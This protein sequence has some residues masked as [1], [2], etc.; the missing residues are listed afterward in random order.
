[1]VSP[2]NIGL[3]IDHD[4]VDDVAD[5]ESG[6]GS[7]PERL[8]ERIFIEKVDYLFVN[9]YGVIFAAFVLSSLLA[10]SLWLISKDIVVVYWIVAYS[11]ISVVRIQ[12]VRRY[13]SNPPTDVK[14]SRKWAFIWVSSQLLPGIM[15]GLAS[16]LF[17]DLNNLA[18]VAIIVIFTLGITTGAVSSTASYYP[19]Y[20]SFLIPSTLPL[21]YLRR[22]R[23]IRLRRQ[24]QEM[25]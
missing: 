24:A 9:A 8:E 5:R 4:A 21:A 19:A 2:S 17:L 22:R 13:K 1:M 10:L 14:H 11:L 15:W 20:Y 6:F 7:S 23:S 18:T 25:D 16:I 12:L 3:D